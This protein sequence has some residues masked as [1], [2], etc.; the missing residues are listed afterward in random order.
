MKSS[1]VNKLAFG[2][3]MA[4]AALLKRERVT[5]DISGSMV[6]NRI[7]TITVQSPY[8]P[9]VADAQYSVSGSMSLPSRPWQSAPR[10]VYFD[11]E[12]TM[13]TPRIY[14]SKRS[15]ANGIEI[16]LREVVLSGSSV[17]ISGT[18]RV[19]VDVFVFVSHFL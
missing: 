18:Y 5:F 9:F 8:S 17:S 3:G 19:H 16:S 12:A 11:G 1:T 15:T 10:S 4:G 7:T 2:S 6:N 14:L 13:P